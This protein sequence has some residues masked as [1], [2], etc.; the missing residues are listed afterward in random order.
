MST[1]QDALWRALVTGDEACP[2]GQA[3]ARLGNLVR[4]HAECE[5]SADFASRVLAASKAA[6][7]EDNLIDDFYNQDE[8]ASAGAADPGLAKIRRLARRGAEVPEPVDLL[9]EVLGNLHRHSSRHGNQAVDRVTRLRIWATVIVGHVAAII[10]IVVLQGQ[11]IDTDALIPE[12]DYA[13]PSTRE[14]RLIEETQQRINFEQLDKETSEAMASGLPLRW[15]QLRGEVDT[16]FLLRQ[17]QHLKD[18]YRRHYGT[19]TC[20][21]TVQAGLQWLSNQQADNGS[22]IKP[23]MEQGSRALATQSVALLA[24]LADGVHGDEQRLIIK[25]GATF[26]KLTWFNPEDAAFNDGAINANSDVAHG[27]AML[28]LVES[29]LLL[30]DDAL[31]AFCEK[32][33]NRNIPSQRHTKAGL[34]GYF[35]LAMETANVGN[36]RLSAEDLAALRNRARS[37]SKRDD[38]GHQGLMA[39]SGFLYGYR[40]TKRLHEQLTMMAKAL[41][42][43]DEHKRSDPLRWFFPSLAVREAGGESW[44]QWNRSLQQALLPC[45]EYNNVDKYAWV[46]HRN[47]RFAENDVFATGLVLL[48]LQTAHRYIP[49]ARSH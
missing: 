10:T 25:R 18:L 30:K 35:L 47:V 46:S 1:D 40:N 43:L 4:E 13:M 23:H 48:N 32:A 15:S 27:M 42:S 41:P 38:V 11:L 31:I 12:T 49:L 37:G 5:V 3:L 28:A 39:L 34:D 20:K 22:F 7:D 44:N 24:L 29:S 36:L 8:R 17:N 45:F 14:Q 9:P 19:D 2:D 33:L 26:L 6:G 16:L 21:A